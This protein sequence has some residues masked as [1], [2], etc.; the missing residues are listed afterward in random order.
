MGEK[1][2]AAARAV[3][4]VGAGTCEFI[5]DTETNIFYFMEMN[6]RLQ[7]E[8]PVTEMITGMDLVEWQ[9]QVASGNPLPK[10]QEELAIHGHCFE[11]R[12]YSENPKNDFLPVTGQLR[13]LKPPEEVPNEVRVE[14]GVRQ[15]DNV[16][17]YYDPMIAKLV[18]WGKTRDEAL[19][20]LKLNL[21]NYHIVG[22]SNNIEFLKKVATHKEFIEG[23]VDTNFIA[24]NAADLF[25]K[26]VLCPNALL[27]TAA[28]VVLR[29]EFQASA[30]PFELT[31]LLTKNTTANPWSQL[32]GFRLNHFN[33]VVIDLE[34]GEGSKHA[35]RILIQ[36]K[37]TL[38]LSSSSINAKEDGITVTSKSYDAA[39]N[40]VVLFIDGVKQ[41]GTVVFLDDLSSVTTFTNGATYEFKL[42]EIKLHSDSADEGAASL[43]SP[44]PGKI[45]QVSVKPGEIVA[46]G[47]TLM[48]VEAMKMEH[49]IKA[50]HAGI[51]KSI[52][53]KPGDM[54]QKGDS[55]ID[56]E[57]QQPQQK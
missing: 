26:Q 30:K 33:E 13:Y 49:S 2:V 15:G 6:T 44:M 50:P 20:R 19:R 57:H 11:A 5:V 34:D 21:D 4:Y 16:S 3:Q 43:R 40:E 51:I 9:L 25:P 35:V 31:G 29:A 10:M 1:A 48:I 32:G 14:S 53:F 23:G 8:H 18:V 28:T 41:S 27:M 24:K 39:T 46:K 7:V 52:H 17:I 56:V 22:L 47:K 38:R 37:N 42:A 36:D 55:L 45:I 54:V 12:V